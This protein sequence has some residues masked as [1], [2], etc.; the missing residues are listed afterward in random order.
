[1]T[2]ISL[3]ARKSVPGEFCP[4]EHI[5]KTFRKSRIPVIFIL[6]DFNTQS[7]SSAR[8]LPNKVT[9][10]ALVMY[11]HLFLNSVPSASHQITF[12][13]NRVATV[14]FDPHLHYCDGADPGEE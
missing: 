14:D 1:V 6:C 12:Y 2:I 7:Y 9:N 13:E 3:F 11:N 4:V 8:F 10:P 5:D